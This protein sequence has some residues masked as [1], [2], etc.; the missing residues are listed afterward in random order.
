MSIQESG[1]MYLESIL[2]LSKEKPSIRAIDLS[3]Y[4]IFKAKREPS[5]WT[6]QKWW[7]CHS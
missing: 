2:V 7:F 1:E 6:S 4:M 5:S 3:E